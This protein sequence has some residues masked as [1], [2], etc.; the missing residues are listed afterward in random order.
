MDFPSLF[1][2]I[3]CIGKESIACLAPL[4][5][6][7]KALSFD[8]LGIDFLHGVLTVCVLLRYSI[9]VLDVCGMLPFEIRK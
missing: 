7:K 3:V 6:S 1:R 8:E 2:I 4:M 9:K 5:N